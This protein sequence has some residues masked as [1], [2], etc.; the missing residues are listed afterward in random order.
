MEVRTKLSHSVFFTVVAFVFQV[1]IKRFYYSFTAHSV[2]NFK[3]F[4]TG[5]NY[6]DYSASATMSQFQ[7]AQPGST[8]VFAPN[9][10]LSGAAL[11]RTASQANTSQSFA[12][13][14]TVYGG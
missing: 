7:T 5:N 10:V 8:A 6:L 11:R 3:E 9:S 1:F 12:W 14:E 13:E 4:F 2:Q